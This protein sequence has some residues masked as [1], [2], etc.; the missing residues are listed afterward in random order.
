MTAPARTV[1]LLRHAHAEWPGYT[2]RDF[3]RP[4]TANGES[5]AAAA[6][7]AIRAAGHRPTL[8]LASPA[9]RTRQTAET[10][11]TTLGLSGT[12]IMYVEALYNASEDALEEALHNHGAQAAH[13]VLVAHNPGISAL[14]RR[15]CGNKALPALQPGDWLCASLPAD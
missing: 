5:D 1:L 15:L 10:L 8:I 12:S 9:R 14:A 4:L 11:A 13:V 7:R 6:A 3:D 2:G